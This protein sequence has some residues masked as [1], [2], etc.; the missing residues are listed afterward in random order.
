M[1]SDTSIGLYEQQLIMSHWFEWSSMLFI[2]NLKWI[3]KDCKLEKV[4]DIIP[5]DPE[6]EKP[7]ENKTE[8]WMKNDGFKNGFG[9]KVRLKIVDSFI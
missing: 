6:A 8:T 1:I 4:K 2:V 3:N 7:N 9:L 5:I